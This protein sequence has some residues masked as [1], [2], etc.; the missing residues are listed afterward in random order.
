MNLSR[1]ADLRDDVPGDQAAA[2]VQVQRLEAR[3][4]LR[5]RQGEERRQ[6]E[7]R[8]PAPQVELDGPRDA[9]E[10]LPAAVGAGLAALALLVGRE[11]E[12]E[13]AGGVLVLLV[14]RAWPSRGRSSRSRG[15]WGTSPA[16]ELNEKSLGSSSG[17]D[18]PVS[19]SVRVVE[20]Q[21]RTSPRGVS[22]K[23]APLPSR[24]ARSSAG[25]GL[26]LALQVGHDDLDV[27]LAVAVELLEGVDARQAPVGAHELEALP[28]DP[29]RDRLV[30]ALAPAHE[31]RAQV[32]VPRA[33]GPAVREHAGEEL[34]QGARRER[35]D[36]PVGV[37]VVLHPE[38][39]VEQ[40]QV[41]GHLRYRGHGRLERAA[42]DALLDGDGGRDAGQP[43]DRGPRQL[44]D[45]LARVGRHR[46][47]EPALALGEDDVEGQGRL[48]RAGDAGDD[49]QP[50]VGDGDREVL[51][52]VLARA[53]D[54]DRAGAWRAGGAC[55][56]A[57]RRRRRLA[58]PVERLREEG[59]GRGPGAA[60]PTRACPRR[61]SARRPSPAS[62][63][64]SMIQSAHLR[65]SRLCSIT[66]RLWP[67][68]TSACRTPR[69]L[70]TSWRWRPV[71]GSSRR[72]SAP[73]S[74]GRVPR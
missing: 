56:R 67:R 19:T 66:T 31:R 74:P 26:A 62:G 40:A 48:P 69:S 70:P 43:V 20:N 64:I 1:L 34:P 22:R 30:V 5:G 29:V 10:A 6:R 50:A 41:L 36:R 63:P 27:V 14:L 37:R 16:A 28:P 38:A 54:L 57:R 25:P 32:E 7:R 33:A 11:P 21:E 72:R 12:V 8:A 42:R 58:A 73:A 24:S 15:T 61:R 68:S 45:E 55:P 35:R 4:E 60:R 53:D 51:Q 44:L 18:S 13:Q 46:L 49:A 59:R 17:K 2:L 9:V 47:H 23:Q 65:T 3:E 52:V 39:R 71:V